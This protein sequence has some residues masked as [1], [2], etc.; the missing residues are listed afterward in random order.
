[1]PTFSLHDEAALSLAGPGP[2]AD[3]LRRIYGS[4]PTTTRQ[5]DIQIRVDSIDEPRG[6]V[7]ASPENG[8]ARDDGFLITYGDRRARLSGDWR[9]VRVEPGFSAARTITLA[10]GEL[11]KTLAAR[12]PATAMIHASAVE[13]DGETILFPAW[14]GSGKTNTLLTF[15]EAGANHVA[16][17]RLWVDSTGMVRGYPTPL[18][19]HRY[20]LRSFPEL[21]PTFSAR[22]A[23]FGERVTN[24]TR[25]SLSRLARATSVLND[26]LVTQSAWARV[27]EAFPETTQR[28]ETEVDRI[29]LLQ[30]T[31]TDDLSRERLDQ[32][33]F[34]T[35]M[36][37]IHE[38]EWNRDL[39]GVHRAF[40]TLFDGEKSEELDTL[41]ERERRVINTVASNSPLYRLSVP[42]RDRWDDTLKR[43]LL[44]AVTE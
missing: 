44:E 18:H 23:R 38:D 35:A 36:A 22:R 17:D 28:F 27:H 37:A 13:Y 9:T 25:R 1:M 33:P 32:E 4:F 31:T 14:K 2:I 29:V 26:A 21:D 41:R 15:L 34:S 11:R 30:A 16:D 5:P 20:N 39:E 8:Y 12:D 10:E 42:R 7:L 40:D 24:R 3:Q 6:P 19:L 43:D